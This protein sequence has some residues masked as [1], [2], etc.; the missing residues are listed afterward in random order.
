MPNDNPETVYDSLDESVID[1][2]SWIKMWLTTS[3]CM[4]SDRADCAEANSLLV[5]IHEA[6]DQNGEVRGEC[7]DALSN[8]DLLLLE[9]LGILTEDVRLTRDF[10]NGECEEE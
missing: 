3:Y 4:A 5:L 2:S 8:E 1:H 10:F 7:L 9:S 6:V